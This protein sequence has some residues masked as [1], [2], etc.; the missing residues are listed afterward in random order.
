MFLGLKLS[1]KGGKT[2]SVAPPAPGPF[3]YITPSQTGIFL[4]PAS[5]DKY[6]RP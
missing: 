4:R 6:I 5:T 3:V 2:S 1:L